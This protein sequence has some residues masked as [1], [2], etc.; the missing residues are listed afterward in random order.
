MQV[1]GA[2]VIQGVPK[3]KRK[4]IGLRFGGTGSDPGSGPGNR[5]SSGDI[6]RL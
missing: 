2:V 6:K 4:K 5:T 1:G 3:S